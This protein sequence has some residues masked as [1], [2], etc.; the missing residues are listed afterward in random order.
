MKSK[1]SKFVKKT[2]KKTKKICKNLLFIKKQKK[3]EN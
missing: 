2:L 1:F 3:A